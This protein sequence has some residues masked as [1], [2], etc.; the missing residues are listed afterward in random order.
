MIAYSDLL[1]VIILSLPINS[2]L[3]ETFHLVHCLLPVT[4][5]P[6]A[7]QGLPLPEIS[8]GVTVMMVSVAMGG[9]ILP[10]AKAHQQVVGRYPGGAFRVTVENNDELQGVG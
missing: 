5:T 10:K 9:T 6:S 8:Q 2:L 4:P 7:C 1:P 3:Q